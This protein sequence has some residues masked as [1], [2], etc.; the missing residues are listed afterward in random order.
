MADPKDQTA[1]NG[2]N[3]AK[4]MNV[5]RYCKGLTFRTNKAVEEKDADGNVVKVN[6]K[7]RV[8]YLPVERDLTPD[9]LLKHYVDGNEVVLVTKDGRK[10]R[11]EK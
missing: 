4:P 10:H 8:K 1:G 9:D 11:V 6:G 2:E 7:P 3:G 5:S